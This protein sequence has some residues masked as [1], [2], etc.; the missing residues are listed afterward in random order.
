[1][2]KGS[3]L[4]A[5]ARQWSSQC[6]VPTLLEIIHYCAEMDYPDRWTDILPAILYNI[7]SSSDYNCVASSVEALKSITLVCG[8]SAEKE[9]TL[10]N[11]CNR[12]VVPL[13]ELANKLFAN[14]SV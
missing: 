5:L 1:V 13:L 9:V 4:E 12:I 7:S 14:Y 6:L 8:K 10:N 3:I 2:I 11:L